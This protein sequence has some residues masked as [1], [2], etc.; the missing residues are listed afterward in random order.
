MEQRFQKGGGSQRMREEFPGGPW[1][2][3]CNSYFE[4]Y[5]FSKLKE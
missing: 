1:I 3:F 4:V 5:L 2:H